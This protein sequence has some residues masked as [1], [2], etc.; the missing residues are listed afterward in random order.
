M[1][2][3]S[4]R[5]FL[6]GVG[7][8]AAGLCCGGLLSACASPDTTD[9]TAASTP[10]YVSP[11]DLSGITFDDAGRATYVEGGKVC[12]KTC[13]DV[14]DHQGA[15]DWLSV[16][17][18]GIDIAIVRI[19]YR[20]TS[21]GS[22]HADKRFKL[23]LAGAKAVGLQVGAYMFSQA[24]SD[25][26]ADEEAGFALDA[27][28]GD[29]LD[30]PLVY[31]LEPAGTPGTRAADLTVDQATSN[32][33]VFC[34]RVADAGYKPMIYGN[35]GDI[36]RVDLTR[37]SSYPVWYAEYETTVPAGQFDFCMWQYSESGSVSGISG[38][39]DLS[40]YFT[41][42]CADRPWKDAV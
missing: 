35:G 3:M 33:S 10:A 17:E 19:G 30:L 25:S 31:D 16:A 34:K 39:A 24:I 23:N 8:G 13:V 12:S 27:L 20:G 32:A 28:G 9:D 29:S 36:A 38:G 40:L 18:D 2:T 41:D 14:S 22:V 15:I 42:D 37:L 1:M 5:G 4:R 26:E 6:A 11:Y 7:L 21:E